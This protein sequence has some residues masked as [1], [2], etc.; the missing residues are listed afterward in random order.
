MTIVLP[1]VFFAVCLGLFARRITNTH[2]IALAGVISL[3]IAVQFL[4]H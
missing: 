4:K 2:W 3:V 1:I